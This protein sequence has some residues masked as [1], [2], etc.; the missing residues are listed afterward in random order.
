LYGF[1][2]SGL[3]LP[4]SSTSSLN[5][6]AVW[7]FYSELKVKL[8]FAAPNLP[9]TAASKT[10]TAFGSLPFEFRQVHLI[11]RYWTL[12]FGIAPHRIPAYI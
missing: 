12:S 7:H 6:N 11:S 8:L 3:S 9:C 2:L 5:T 1:F 10:N 4:G